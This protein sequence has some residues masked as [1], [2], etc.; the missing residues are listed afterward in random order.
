MT[1]SPS[2]TSF[3]KSLV[4]RLAYFDGSPVPS[5]AA[6]AVRSADCFIASSISLFIDWLSAAGWVSGRNGFAELG[7]FRHGHD[8]RP[9]HRPVAWLKRL[10]LIIARLVRHAVRR[11]R[12]PFAKKRH[13]GAAR[14]V[15]LDTSLARAPAPS[16]AGPIRNNQ[17]PAT[18]PPRSRA[19]DTIRFAARI[20]DALGV[21]GGSRHLRTA[22]PTRCPAGRPNAGS[23]GNRCPRK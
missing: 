6:F 21:L 22:P 20:L 9:D 11:P 2:T 16:P 14:P 23:S 3:R 7:I 13:R 4:C 1:L 17:P 10:E 5:F 15:C 18:T 12:R 19:K 8:V